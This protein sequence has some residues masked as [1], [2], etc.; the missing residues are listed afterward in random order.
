MAVKWTVLT[1]VKQFLALWTHYDYYWCIKI[2]YFSTAPKIIKIHCKFICWH[3]GIYYGGRGA[4]KNQ[5]KIKV[6]YNQ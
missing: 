5:K 4:G 1:V 2:G 3:F 6:K